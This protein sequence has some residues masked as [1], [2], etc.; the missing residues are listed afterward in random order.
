MRT[1]TSQRWRGLAT[2]VV[3]AVTHGSTAIERIQKQTVG[4]PLSLL[5]KLPTVGPIAHLVH[6]VHDASVSGVHGAV[7]LVAHATR[8]VVDLAFDVVDQYPGGRPP[9]GPPPPP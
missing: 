6:V 2:L 9:L 5:E 4:R 7:R 3:D 1:S 8:E